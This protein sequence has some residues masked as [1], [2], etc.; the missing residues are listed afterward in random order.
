MTDAREPRDEASGVGGGGGG[1]WGEGAG[2][3]GIGLKVIVGKQGKDQG[4]LKVK[5]RKE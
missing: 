4:F 1:G 3:G 5:A 2:R